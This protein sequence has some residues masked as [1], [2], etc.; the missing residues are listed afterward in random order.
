[1]RDIYKV[2]LRGSTIG[3]FPAPTWADAAKAGVAAHRRMTGESVAWEHV[4]ATWVNPKHYEQESV[5]AELYANPEPAEDKAE[6][7]PAS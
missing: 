1:M 5:P 7:E 6:A 4:T 3:F 2:T